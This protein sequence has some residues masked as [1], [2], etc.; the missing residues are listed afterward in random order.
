MKAAIYARRSTEQ[1]VAEEAKSV[2]RQVENARAFAQS[3]G[4]TVEDE[5][6]YI[7]DGVSGAEF[8]RRPGLQRMLAAA[9][10]GAFDMLVVSEQKSIGR[11]SVET[12]FTIKRLSQ[13]GVEVFEYVHGGSLTP[14]N[15][16]EKM[17]SAIRAGADETHREQT[18]ERMHEAHKRL[19]TK[20]YVAGGRLFGYR[21]VHVFSGKDS[22]GNP[23]RSHVDREINGDEAAV[24]RR[25]FE[26]YAGGDGLKAITKALN[27]D[28]APSP[29]YSAPKD[30]LPPL[31]GWAPSTVRA[32]LNREIYRGVV[33]W[34]KRRKRDQH[35]Q[36][37]QV[38]A[39]ARRP[40]SAWVRAE[41]EDLRIV[42]DELWSRV[43][44]RR[45]DV[46]GHA[47]RFASGRISG[48]PPKGEARNLLAGL[49][50]CGRC[51]GGLIVNTSTGPRGGAFSLADLPR[52]G[53]RREGPPAR[54]EKYHYYVCARRRANGE[55]D[56]DLRIRTDDVNEAVLQSIEEHALTPEAI[57]QVIKLNER[58]EAR[59]QQERLRKEAQDI[60]RR[61]SRLMDAIEGGAD[62]KSLAAR[63]KE[64]EAKL[65]AIRA[66]LAGL[67]PVPRLPAAVVAD[68]LAEWRRL[69][70]SSITQGRAV[71]Q[72][73]L[74]GRI[75]FM[76]RTDGPGYDFECPTRFDKLFSGV[77]VQAANTADL[78]QHAGEG[79][80]RITIE[81]T[82][83]G[84]YERL[85][86]AAERAHVKGVAT[87]EGAQPFNAD[88]ASDST[89]KGVRPWR[90]SNPRSSP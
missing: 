74:R 4:W 65:A 82:F 83:D 67:Q 37:E 78:A 39:R 86:A 43:A 42:S 51:G 72:R 80:E 32:I 85:L 26:L 88:A 19:A 8:D 41:R 6:V 15:A 29:R 77:V 40:E 75:T 23:L 28:K 46:E 22:Q 53:E 25:I 24:V 70:R 48:R 90:D 36:V 7:D 49:A 10:R 17:M 73:V 11:E 56:N 66:E 13:A 34:N 47:L 50:T 54:G 18:S 84:S 64:N 71:L 9:Q 38:R 31:G 62:A 55:C 44:S 1:N 5:H 12:N 20:G 79:T 35:G 89:L 87:P 21:N 27:I 16:L 81:D 33:V 2:T 14:K 76:P 63:V 45:A 30:G 58:N 68:R 57:E 59:E 61:I 52:P 69:L 60:E 3:R